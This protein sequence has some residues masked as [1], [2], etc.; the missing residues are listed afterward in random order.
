MTQYISTD[1]DTALNLTAETFDTG[2]AVHFF[3][4][5]ELRCTVAVTYAVETG[6]VGTCFRG[7]ENIIAGIDNDVCGGKLQQSPRLEL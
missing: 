6:Q 1:H 3:K 4:V 7:G 5:A 2:V